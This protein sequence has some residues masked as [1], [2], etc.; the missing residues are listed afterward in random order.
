MAAK[1]HGEVKLINGKRV[2][3]PEYR[4]WQ[5]MKNR[6]NN[7]KTRDY[8]YYGGRGITVCR[9]W[10]ADFTAF[11]ADMG[12]RPSPEH[13]LERR[14]TNRGYSPSNCYWAT[15]E[16]QSRNRR[17]ATTR[18]WELA[19][20]LGVSV[21]TAAHYLWIVRRELRG[22]PTRYTVPP[23]AV[24]VIKKHMKEKL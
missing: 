3:T 8:P 9:R 11:L 22:E 13:T 2:A 20:K 14:N 24:P 18:I 5:M 1:S 15:R 19:A 23:A 10:A 4:S 6:C 21:A 16:A 17:Y 7:P 12:R